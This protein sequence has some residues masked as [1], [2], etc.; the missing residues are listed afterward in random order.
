MT[1]V[2]DGVGDTSPTSVS[3]LGEPSDWRM[4]SSRASVAAETAACSALQSSSLEPAELEEPRDEEREWDEVELIADSSHSPLSL[5]NT[6]VY[7]PLL[8][9][10]ELT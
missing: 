6:Q 7:G 4:I 2:G 5:K 10:S 8:Q 9:K 3:A 1:G